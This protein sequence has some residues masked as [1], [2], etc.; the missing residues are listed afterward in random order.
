MGNTVNCPSCRQALSVPDELLGKRVKC[1]GCREVFAAGARPAPPPPK[2]EEDPG[3][4]DRDRDRDRDR[5]EDDYPR[6]P[7]RSERYRERDRED[8]EDEDD[9]YRLRRRRGR[10]RPGKVQAIGVMML[11]G[12]IYALVHAA[13]LVIGSTCVCLLWPGVYLAIVAGILGILKASALLGRDA[14]RESLPRTVA[15]LQIIC[16]LNL[17]MIN[18]A[19]GIIELVFMN[20][21]EVTDYLRP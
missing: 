7:R 18:L 19:L 1:P 5:E 10:D 8:E 11:C 6:R 15:I 4:R 16:I 21:P 3:R 13:G 12:S 14:R 17:D 2:D 9:R 20:D